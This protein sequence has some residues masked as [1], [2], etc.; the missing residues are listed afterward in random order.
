MACDLDLPIAA[1]A[2]DLGA[3]LVT[4]DRAL[5]DGAIAGLRVENWV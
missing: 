5:L 4:N 2:L 1:T 3:T